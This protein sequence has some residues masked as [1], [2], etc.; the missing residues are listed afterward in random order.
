MSKSVKPLLSLRAALVLGL[1]A[2]VGVGV[3][4]LTYADT[5]SVPRTAIA[6]LAASGAALA[7]LNKIVGDDGDR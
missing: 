3:A 1:S 2:L 7:L 4:A 6:A 5:A